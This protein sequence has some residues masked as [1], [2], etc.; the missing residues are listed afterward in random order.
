MFLRHGSVHP[1]VAPRVRHRK[2]QRRPASRDSS[3]L[4]ENRFKVFHVVDGERTQELAASTTSELNHLCHY[5]DALKSCTA[6]PPLQPLQYKRPTP[7]G[8]RLRS[9]RLVTIV[10]RRSS[11]SFDSDSSNFGCEK[12]SDAATI[13]PHISS[14]G[15]FR[16]NSPDARPS[17]IT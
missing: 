3:E 13:A 15:D 10:K 5:I 14:S 1:L 11:S 9:T 2:H 16:S 12:H 8:A 4:A 7:Q 17:I 6:Y